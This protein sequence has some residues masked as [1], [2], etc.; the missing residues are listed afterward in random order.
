MWH[1][2]CPVLPPRDSLAVLMRWTQAFHHSVKQ[3]CVV[4]PPQPLVFYACACTLITMSSWQGASPS[5]RAGT[6]CCLQ[7]FKKKKKKKKKKN[8]NRLWATELAR[9][10]ILRPFETVEASINYPKTPKPP[11]STD[12]H[13]LSLSAFSL[14]VRPTWRITKLPL[15][16]IHSSIATSHPS[17]AGLTRP[18]PS[19]LYSE[20]SA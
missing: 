8:N 19:V 3:L 16:I 2:G 18:R 14:D 11:V 5:V 10:L 1:I 13:A 15:H 12:L 7:N 17:L 9:F 4:H 6:S 20:Y